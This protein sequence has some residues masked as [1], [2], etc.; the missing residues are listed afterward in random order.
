MQLQIRRGR[1]MQ[2]VHLAHASSVQERIGAALSDYAAGATIGI[3]PYAG[4][5]LPVLP[6]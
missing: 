5:V 6:A 4:L 2:E 3:M 1:R